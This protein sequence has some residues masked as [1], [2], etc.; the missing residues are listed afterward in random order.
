MRDQ[1]SASEGIDAQVPADCFESGG[2]VEQPPGDGR[3]HD[4][5]SRSAS[6]EQR[7]AQA[8]LQYEVD[9]FELKMSKRDHSCCSR[10]D[11]RNLKPE[12]VSVAGGG[13]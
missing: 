4:E 8:L 5:E 2:G 12:T 11:S 6:V 13:G 3:R 7:I 9:Q 10:H 1:W